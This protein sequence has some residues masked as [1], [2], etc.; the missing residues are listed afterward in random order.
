MSSTVG[1]GPV[2]SR[3]HSIGQCAEAVDDGGVA[4]SVGDDGR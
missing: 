1:V 2:L 3:A 4:A